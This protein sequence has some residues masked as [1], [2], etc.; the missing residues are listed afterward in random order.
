MEEEEMMPDKTIDE[1]TEERQVSETRDLTQQS[2]S[3]P[4]RPSLPSVHGGQSESRACP[5]EERKKRAAIIYNSSNHNFKRAAD[6]YFVMEVA[7]SMNIPVGMALGGMYTVNGRLRA[8]SEMP[9]ALAYRSG[10]LES[11]REYVIDDKYN[12]ICLANK[13]INATPFAAVSVLKRKGYPVSESVF[14]VEDAK[15]AGLLNDPKKQTYK[16]YLKKMLLSKARMYNIQYNFPDH[17][18]GIN[19]HEADVSPRDVTPKETKQ[20]LK[21]NFEKLTEGGDR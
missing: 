13:N 21:D 14:S 4:Q 18:C 7:E 2:P 11:Y 16:K 6:I 8:H 17:V 15:T 10:E 20:D 1:V 3:E 12:E 9:L 19:D 5:I